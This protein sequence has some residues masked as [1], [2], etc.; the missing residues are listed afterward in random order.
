MISYI[1]SLL[2][3][4]KPRPKCPYCHSIWVW[5]DY[6]E[7]PMGSKPKNWCLKCDEEWETFLIE[8]N[9]LTIQEINKYRKWL[10]W[11]IK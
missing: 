4:I 5:W 2:H 11:L 7:Q 1:R 8:K 6:I 9:T 10:S 3:N